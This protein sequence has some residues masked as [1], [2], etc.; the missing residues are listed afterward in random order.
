MGAQVS[1][2]ELAESRDFVAGLGA[3]GVIAYQAERFEDVVDIVDLV[4]DPIGGEM[5]DRSWQV[6]KRG[7]T[8]ISTV[9]KPDAPKATAV[10]VTAK[11]YTAQPDGGRL[12]EI[13]SLID[14]CRAKVAIDKVFPLAE[15]A[16]AERH[17]QEDH[18]VG[19]V[20]LKMA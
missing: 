8:L 11:R 17:L 14:D 7:G 16:E 12:E 20:I 6:L 4:Y 9:Y 10:G 5:E 1:A 15:A 3:Y 2:T 18:V 13:A 19:K